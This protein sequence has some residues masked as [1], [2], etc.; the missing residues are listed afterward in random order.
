MPMNGEDERS[1]S[2]KYRGAREAKMYLSAHRGPG[3]DICHG[4]QTARKHKETRSQTNQQEKTQT[5]TKKYN[6][7]QTT[8]ILPI[9][10]EQAKR[11]EQKG[12]EA[13]GTS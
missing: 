7:K 2:I 11:A 1:G 10:R 5:K 9:I 8:E 4:W 12:A 3:D 13:H 6:Q